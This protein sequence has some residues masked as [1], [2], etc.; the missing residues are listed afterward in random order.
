[1]L[2]KGTYK[3]KD[4]NKKRNTELIGSETER[5]IRNII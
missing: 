4:S 2:A 1:M 3:V 5:E